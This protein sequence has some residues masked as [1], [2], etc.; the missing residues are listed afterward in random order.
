MWPLAILLVL[1]F[2]CVLLAPPRLRAFCWILVIVIGVVPWFS[3]T[4]HAHWPRIGWIPFSSPPIRPRDI[5][6]NAALY[7][8]LG[9]FWSPRRATATWRHAAGVA[10]WACCLSAATELTQVYSHGRFPSMTDVTM[11]TLGAWA[12][13]EL[14]A[15]LSAPADRTPPSP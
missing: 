3:M 5:A 8:P 7:L 12:G 11:N 2:L 13:A 4:N 10:L 15:R 14:R 6:L 9:F 1:A